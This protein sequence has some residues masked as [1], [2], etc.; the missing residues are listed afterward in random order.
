MRNPALDV[1]LTAVKGVIRI[2]AIAPTMAAKPKEIVVILSTLIPIKMAAS[3]FTAQAF[4]HLP[5]KVLSKKMLRP[6]AIA[7]VPAIIHGAW[8]AIETPI[9][10][11]DTDLL[12]NEGRLKVALSVHSITVLSRKVPTAISIITKDSGAA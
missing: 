7:I 9:K 12:K 3:R 5:I 1:K 8:L 4:M 6:R 2:P 11:E 10:T